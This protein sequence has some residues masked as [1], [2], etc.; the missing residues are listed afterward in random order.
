VLPVAIQSG[1][2]ALATIILDSG[3]IPAA[4]LTESLEAAKAAKKADMVALLEKAGAKPFEDFKIDAAL[5]A[6]FP[7]TYRGPTGNELTIV[8]AG[9]RVTIGAPAAPP[10]QRLVL[11]ATAERAFKALGA[12][13][14]VTFQVDGDKVTGFSLTQGAAQPVAFTRVEGK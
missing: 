12:P 2:T 13:V 10:E 1:D 5:L 14:A 11:V 3:G 6:K 4:A 8:G 9:A 7:G